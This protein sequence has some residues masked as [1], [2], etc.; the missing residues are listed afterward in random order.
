MK[1]FYLFWVVPLFLGWAFDFLFWRHFPGISLLLYLLLLVGGGL[2]V[3][4]DNGFRPSW[5]SLLLLPPILFFAVMTILRREPMTVFLAVALSVMLL[6]LLSVTYQGGRWLQY[7]WLDYLVQFFWLVV[8]LLVRP[9]LWW[10]ERLKQSPTSTTEE[11]KASVSSWQP[12]W[13][14]LR[15]VLITFPILV[16]FAVLLASADLVFAERLADF[17]EIFRLERLPEYLFRLFYILLFAHLIAGALLHAA[18]KS[19]EEKLIGFARPSLPS[20][21]G[22]TEAAIVLG[23]V[24]LLFGFFVLI[25][26]Q[27]FFGGQSNIG[28]EGY[29]YAEYARR[30]FGELVIVAFFS[31]LLFLGLSTTT[32]RATS[33]QRRLFSALGALLVALVNVIL[34]SAFQRLVLYETAYGFTRLRMYTHVFMIW[35]GIL[36][37]AV[38]VLEFLRRERAFALAMLLAAIGFAVTLAIVNVDSFIARQNVLRAMQ[39][40]ELDI[41]YLALLSTDAVPSLV[42][43]LQE[44]TLPTDT[45]D[46]VGAA[47]LCREYR[48]GRNQEAVNW[49]SWTLSAW[50]AKRALDQVQRILDNY[51]IFDQAWPVLVETPLG[52]HYECYYGWLE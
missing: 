44:E 5:K 3:L 39:G 17:L 1:R 50:F 41:N 15:G 43:S 22:F 29:T 46:L 12:F 45:R 20:F 8:S 31:L 30:G 28:L 34:V 19:Q 9:F 38:V 23:A 24:N 4:L 36:L 48:F 16:I 40:E 25:Q 27:Y 32:F 7:G 51:T 21:L 26:F 52:K 33:A 47:L 14:I 49:R 37:V 13:A 18:Q 11:T 42:A 10:I 6:S 2:L 35:L